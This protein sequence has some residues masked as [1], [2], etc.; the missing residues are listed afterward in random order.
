MKARV[1]HVRMAIGFG[2]TVL[3]AVLM[4]ASFG[5]TP[6]CAQGTCATTNVQSTQFPYCQI[7]ADCKDSGNNS[8]GNGSIG[9]GLGAVPPGESCTNESGNNEDCGTFGGFVLSQ[10]FDEDTGDLADQVYAYCLCSM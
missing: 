5:T 3:A 9:A 1:F 6:V 4:I 8:C 7:S 2:V 10:L